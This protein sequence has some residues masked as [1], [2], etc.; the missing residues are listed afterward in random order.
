MNELRKNLC[1]YISMKIIWKFN[2]CRD[3]ACVWNSHAQSMRYDY[4]QIQKRCNFIV[5]I[6]VVFERCQAEINSYDLK[7]FTESMYW[8]FLLLHVCTNLQKRIHCALLIWG[9]CDFVY[10]WG[11]AYFPTWKWITYYMRVINFFRSTLLA[12]PLFSDIYEQK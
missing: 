5:F 12:S 9:W 2:T 4:F 1:S 10:I 6:Q 8:I 11:F 7:A 3:F